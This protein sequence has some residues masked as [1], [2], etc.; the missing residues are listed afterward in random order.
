M[1]QK[2]LSRGDKNVMSCGGV[3]YMASNARVERKGPRP[4]STVMARR[5][6]RMNST[7]TVVRVL[8]G[9]KRV[10]VVLW[11]PWQALSAPWCKEV[12]ANL[13]GLPSLN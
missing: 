2:G 8:A 13:A 12:I 4:G 3:D 9:F 6:R 1:Y 11:Y 7:Y 10:R 5:Y